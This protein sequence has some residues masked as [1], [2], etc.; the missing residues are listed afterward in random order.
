M[1]PEILEGK[2]Y[3]EKVDIYSFGILLWEIMTEKTPYAL[4][5]PYQIMLKVTQGGR[6]D[7]NLIPAD[8]PKEIIAIIKLC[9][10]ADSVKRPNSVDLN[11]WLTAIFAKVL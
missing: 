5:N 7:E 11:S 8:I 6:P 10:N 4:L 9:W 1:A 2:P 3:D